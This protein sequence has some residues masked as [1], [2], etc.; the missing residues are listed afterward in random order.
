MKFLASLDKRRVFMT[1]GVVFIALACGQV[2]QSLGDNPLTRHE[3]ATDLPIDPAARG[4]APPPVM[5]GRA[6]VTSVNRIE[7]V[8]A[9]DACVPQLKLTRAP[10]AMIDLS[11]DGCKAGPLAVTFGGLEVTTTTETNGRFQRRLPAF[12]SDMHVLVAFDGETITADIEVPEARDFQHVAIVWDGPQLLRLHAFEFGAKRDQF[13]HVWAQAPKSPQRAVRG[14]GGFLTK[15]GDGNGTSA[16]I[17]SFPAAHSRKKG[18]VRLVVEGD[19]TP[20]N[21]GLQVDALALQSDPL[22]GMSVT[23]VALKMP[24]C[25]AVGRV[26]RLQNLFQD[27]R[28]A[29]R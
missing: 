20:S 29:G 24:Q 23:E 7:A 15:L 22:G 2:M 14:T 5:Q 17:Y 9:D 26:V 4:L 3:K 25:D 13:G 27:M 1:C 11:F 6:T 10:S 21:C 8:L 18:V 12:S 16:E 28:L 19:V